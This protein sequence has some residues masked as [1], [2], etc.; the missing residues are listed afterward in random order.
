MTLLDRLDFRRGL[1]SQFPPP[2]HRVVYTK[3]ACTSRRPGS[4]THP[5]VIEHTL[6]WAAA[7]GIDEAR[8]LTA[9]LNSDTLTQ[10]VRPL[11]ARGEHNPRHFDK[12]IFQLPIPLYNPGNPE[13]RQLAELAERAE[14]A[15][16]ALELP[17]GTSF[18]AQRRRVREALSRDGVA[19]E[20]NNLTTVLLADAHG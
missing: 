4:A 1:S 10:L 9:I 14:E 2:V 17:S 12:Y 3:A 15:A 6:Y 19:D 18:Q 8:Y 20:I 13:H 7:S 11:Q 16:A 5:A